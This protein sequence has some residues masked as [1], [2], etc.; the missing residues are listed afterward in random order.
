MNKE[1]FKNLIRSVYHK[2]TIK[3]DKEVVRFFCEYY[4]MSEKEVREMFLWA[5]WLTAKL[6]K[7]HNPKTEKEIIRFYENNPFYPFLLIYWH[8]TRKQREFMDYCLKNACGDVLDFGGGTGLLSSKLSE[9]GFNV[10]YADLEGDMFDL[11]KSFLKG[12][13]GIINLSK[14]KIIKKYDTI[15]CIDVIEHIKDPIKTL[16]ILISHLH[17]RG[18]LVINGLESNVT[19]ESPMH[20]EINFNPDIILGNFG[21]IKINK[22]VWIKK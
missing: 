20:F 9:K 5:G 7:C 11:A 21:M 22:Y 2:F 12:K 6:W 14:E 10:D 8:G 3:V 16:K 15:Y 1:C 17:H 18:R 13:A 4:S 19:E